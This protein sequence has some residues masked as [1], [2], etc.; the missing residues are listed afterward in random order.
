V[1]TEQSGTLAPVYTYTLNTN[2]LH[3]TLVTTLPPG[4]RGRLLQVLVSGNGARLYSGRVWARTWNDPKAEWDW[5][6]LPVQPTA[7]QWADAPFPVNPTPPGG[8]PA[9][10][11][12]ANVLS[13]SPTADTWEWA[14]IPIDVTE[15]RVA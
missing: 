13:V 8:E 5:V 3:I 12:W 15:G 1:L 2:G 4:I 6:P 7:P 14:D 11:W 10:W 9:Q